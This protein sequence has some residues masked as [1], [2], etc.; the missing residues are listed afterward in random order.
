LA[1]TIFNKLLIR[2]AFILFILS[3]KTSVLGQNYTLTGSVSDEKTKELLAFVNLTYNNKQSGTT[4]DI[5]GRFKIISSE[6]IQ[7]I[8]LSYV[9]YKNKTIQIPD[10]THKIN[11]QLEQSDF[12][13]NEVV[14]LPGENPA[15]PIIKKVQKNKEINSPQQLPFYSYTSYSKL[16]MTANQDTTKN[17]DFNDT[18]FT[19][20]KKF[21]DKQHLF[22]IE[23][24]T[25]K[26]FKR[27]DKETETILAARVSGFQNP[28]FI[29]LFTQ[30]MT[31]GFYNEV[32]SISDKDYINPIASGTFNKYSFLIE[33]T[34]Y[35][36]NDSIF[37]ISFKPKKG[38][39][40]DGLKGLLYISTNKYAICNVIAQPNEDQDG[41]TIKIQQKYEY[42]QNTQWF[43]T[44]L[45]SDIVFGN[46]KIN[47]FITVGI[48]RTYVKDINLNPDFKRKDFTETGIV[49]AEDAA[50]KGED[51]WNKHRHDS[52]SAKE[53][54]TY[55]MIDSVGK[56]QKFDQKLKVA[57][58]LL[59]NKIRWKILDFDL[60]K[61]FNYNDFEGFRMGASFNTNP[62]FSR[63]FSLGAYGA[64]GTK[65]RALKYGANLTLHLIPSR[66]L[67]LRASFSQDLIETGGSS[68]YNTGRFNALSDDIRKILLERLDSIEKYEVSIHLKPF[69]Y[70]RVNLYVN[71][72]YRS[73]TKNYL[74]YSSNNLISQSVKQNVITEAGAQLYYAYGEKQLKFGNFEISQPTN[75]PVFY[76]NLVKGFNNLF[77]GQLN[78][79]RTDFKAEKSFKTKFIGKTN[80]QILAGYING[81][82]PYSL[83]YNGQGSNKRTLSISVNNSFETM[84][85]NNFAANQFASVFILHDFGRLLYKSKRFEP[86]IGLRLNA[87]FGMLNNPEQHKNINVQDFRRGYYESGL[88]INSILKSSFSNLGFGAFY[89]FGPYNTGNLKDDFTVKLSLGFSF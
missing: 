39:N 87:G 65:D 47:N 46:V 67:F 31:F 27:P 26:K 24:V 79:W 64:F 11:I 60:D 17:P 49:Q 2:V 73:Y 43:P 33:D 81:S 28:S 3:I 37:V 41:T 40:F 69:N 25:E 10:G 22:L 63:L 61:F 52:L 19:K 72:Q 48:G 66:Y 78:Y 14:I 34:L 77:E 4:T 89:R 38:K 20:A 75:Y 68:F 59:A 85:M 74:F 16:I 82:L 29:S 9:G 54:R 80:I 7:S 35:E 57:E 53:L 51:F 76:L 58:I 56:K 5:D 83:L 62:K 44:Q 88:L 84:R 70:A 6:P 32:I 86:R 8:S 36:N 23:Q 45:N 55:Q 21:L 42:I 30:L 18:S 1:L 71:Q 50:K 12:S 13:L 15:H